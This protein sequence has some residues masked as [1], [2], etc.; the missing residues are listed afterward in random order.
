MASGSARRNR[1]ARPTPRRTPALGLATQAAR[2]VP[3]PREGRAMKEWINTQAKELLVFMAN[4]LA[5]AFYTRRFCNDCIGNQESKM[6]AGLNHLKSGVFISAAILSI[7]VSIPDISPL[8]N[9]PDLH[10]LLAAIVGQV[11]YWIIVPYLHYNFLGPMGQPGIDV[12]SFRV[13]YTYYFGAQA[14]LTAFALIYALHSGQIQD[15][16]TV[17]ERLDFRTALNALITISNNGG[18]IFGIVSF[19]ILTNLVKCCCK[20]SMSRAAYSIVFVNAAWSF[21]VSC[22]TSLVCMVE[23]SPLW[24]NK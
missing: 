23:P 8:S 10:L 9:D 13:M 20:I 1:P 22:N 18:S 5:M 14:V 15:L 3:L 4:T 21:F 6:V 19:I 11:A 16:S 7:Y 17:S 2:G 12:Q 24:T